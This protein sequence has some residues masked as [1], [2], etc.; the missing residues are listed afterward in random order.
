MGKVKKLDKHTENFKKYRF[1]LSELV[2]K[3]IKLQYRDSMLGMFW[4]FLQPLLTTIVLVFV[5]NNVF[6]RSSKGVG[7][8][9]FSS[10]AFYTRSSLSPQK[11][12]CAQSV[13]ILQ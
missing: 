6:G 10:V 12:Q 7:N 13:Q 4:T 5:F 9:I 3:N 11:G 1:L 2:R 8:S